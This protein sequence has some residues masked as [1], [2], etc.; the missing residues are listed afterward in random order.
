MNV[1]IAEDN[2]LNAEIATVQLEE[3]GMNVE[4]AVDGKNAVEIFRNQDRKST[5]L[6]SSHYARSRMP[7]SA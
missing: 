4:R 3:F 6:N 5:R 2:E 1:L 7:S